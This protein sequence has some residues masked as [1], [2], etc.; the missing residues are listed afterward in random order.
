MCGEEEGEKRER[1][2]ERERELKTE[3]VERKVERENGEK[4]TSS[5]HGTTTETQSDWIEADDLKE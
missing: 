2:N 1:E 5:P 4:Y 3:E